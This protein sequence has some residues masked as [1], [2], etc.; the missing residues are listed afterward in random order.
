MSTNITLNKPATASNSFAPFLPSLAVDDD[1]TYSKR[2]IT[3][4]IP[5]WLMVDLQNTFW[6]NEWRAYFMGAVGWTKNHNVKEF[7]LEGS[8]DG[9]DWF[10][11][12]SISN[13]ASDFITDKIAP[14]LVHYL[15]INIT[16]GHWNN[17]EIASIVEFKAF[18]PANAPF[19][20]N[21]MPTT[22]SL[23]PAFYSRNFSY[24]ISVA[25]VVDSIAFKPFALQP[26]MEIKVNGIVVTSGSQSQPINLALGSNTVLIT[27]KSDDG[28]M[29]TN[30]TI[31]V[32]RAEAVS[33][34]TTL[35]I[36]ESDL[37]VPVVLTPAF[38]ST[39]LDYTA[40]VNAGFS[41]VKVTPTTKDLTAT[42][43]VN[44][45][46]VPNGKPSG[47]VVL[48]TGSN[49]ITIDVITS[50]GVHCIYHVVI[51]KT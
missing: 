1:I 34:L 11:L 19:L 49:T 22:G 41:S 29:T 23:S 14:R 39:I 47:P 51:T 8:L 25:N 32:T 9:T 28:S 44:G 37:Q 4:H 10:L 3:T 48:N 40:T 7:V 21:L 45:T 30:Y 2:W 42:L 38:S 26:N 17:S 46:V 6:V 15:R 50:G 13:N 33:Y 18:E 12:K 16:K 20:S 24:S 43:K 36:K 27:V 35:S 5:A 31:N